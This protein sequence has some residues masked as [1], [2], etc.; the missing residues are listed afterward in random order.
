M[1]F[2][3]QSNENRDADERG[4]LIHEEVIDCEDGSIF[5]EEDEEEVEEIVE[6]ENVL[7]PDDLVSEIHA[8]LMAYKTCQQQRAERKD[9]QSGSDISVEIEIAE[10]EADAEDEY[11]EQI[12]EQ[13]FRRD[14]LPDDLETACKTL[15]GIVFKGEDIDPTKMMRRSPLPELYRYLKQHY[16]YKVQTQ[17]IDDE[18]PA[19][20]KTQPS[21]ND[22]FKKRA[23]PPS[24]A[25]S[26]E[27]SDTFGSSEVE[28]VL[29]DE[30]TLSGEA[31]IQNHHGD[32]D[33]DDDDEGDVTLQSSD[34]EAEGGIHH[35]PLD[36]NSFDTESGPEIL[37]ESG[38]GDDTT[39]SSFQNSADEMFAATGDA[40]ALN[41]DRRP[42][43]RRRMRRQNSQSSLLL[44]EIL[45]S[46][47]PG[48]IAITE[49]EPT[50]S[51]GLDFD[52]QI[53]ESW[54]VDD[55]NEP[56]DY[57]GACRQLI[58]IIYRGINVDPDVM[59]KRMPLPE[60]YKYLKQ[61]YWFVVH[62][63]GLD[64]YTEGTRDLASSPE[65]EG[66]QGNEYDGST[67]GTEANADEN[68]DRDHDDDETKTAASDPDPDMTMLGASGQDIHLVLTSREGSPSDKN[69]VVDRIENGGHGEDNRD[70]HNEVDIAAENT[71][72]LSNR[73]SG[74]SEESNSAV[75]PYTADAVESS[76]EQEIDYDE[77]S[78]EE[79]ILLDDDDNDDDD[80]DDGNH[81]DDCHDDISLEDEQEQLQEEEE[82]DEVTVEEDFVEEEEEEE[83]VEEEILE[84]V[85]EYEDYGVDDLISD[86]RA[87][88]LAFKL[89]NY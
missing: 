48:V 47:V 62:R 57:E 19:A 59:V 27:K 3:E 61:H 36:T 56:D 22:I 58:P 24:A 79:E 89:K 69:R 55:V 74:M 23:P 41:N 31:T 78:I 72:R 26:P 45:T 53:M 13:W 50:I 75:S 73:K 32:D 70:T 18:P 35:I 7:E 52:E 85:E 42:R 39:I 33:E 81:D 60:L 4:D 20:E 14:E 66:L 29:L 2:T 16:D 40:H 5:T 84:E 83:I 12:I 65:G 68:F 64:E 17:Q 9:S 30:E 21:L 44:Q 38:V 80:C 15:I 28:E 77:E 1:S 67:S 11:E 43:G 87:D 63:R 46:V 88:L 86:V 37:V 10:E 34:Q 54:L 8:S 51:M 6:E 76:N 49:E 71:A 25:V 82:E